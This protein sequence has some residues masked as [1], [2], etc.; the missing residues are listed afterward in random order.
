MQRLLG[1]VF[2]NQRDLETTLVK[3]WLL[4]QR[5][6]AWRW[7]LVP[8]PMDVSKSITLEHFFTLYP[9]PQK[10]HDFIKRFES[11]STQSILD[12][13]LCLETMDW[14]A[15]KLSPANIN[16]FPPESNES[17]LTVS[18]AIERNVRGKYASI[19]PQEKN[20][21]FT[22][23]PS[24]ACLELA[25]MFDPRNGHTQDAMMRDE[26]DH[27]AI[28]AWIERKY[29][30]VSGAILTISCASTEDPQK[31]R[32]PDIKVD[33]I[34]SHLQQLVFD[35]LTDPPE[36]VSTVP[37][38]HQFE[39]IKSMKWVKAL[40]YK[41]E[42]YG[43]FGFRSSKRSHLLVSN[44]VLFAE[45]WGRNLSV[46]IDYLARFPTG[47]NPYSLDILFPGRCH[48]YVEVNYVVRSTSAPAIGPQVSDLTCV[49]AVM[50]WFES[51]R[52][53][54]S[55]D[56]APLAELWSAK[57][58]VWHASDLTRN[59]CCLIPLAQIKGKFIPYIVPSPIKCP[60]WLK[61]LSMRPDMAGCPMMVLPL[62]HQSALGLM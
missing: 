21:K 36:K 29:Y 60:T 57:L 2:T 17:S 1:N 12:E 33:C 10:I 42:A 11:P 15:F 26:F 54:L 50:Q 9:M 13:Y 16:P 28:N 3:R 19:P 7:I 25:Q 8:D 30:K 45:Y 41:L 20:H 61:F 51:H 4:R 56:W 22:S 43:S 40:E 37:S 59:P 46:N 31:K 23:L 44:S 32:I 6:A 52:E 18:A 35:Y 38:Q 14:S 27:P 47:T 53:R 62:P 48:G 24:D 39:Y 5:I 34:Y 55:W 49:F 58:K